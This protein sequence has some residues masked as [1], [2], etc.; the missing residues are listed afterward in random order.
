MRK[1]TLFV[2]LFA[3]VISANMVSVVEAQCGPTPPC[4]PLT[5]LVSYEV[6][7]DKTSYSEM[8]TVTAVVKI[9]NNILYE[10]TAYTLNFYTGMNIVGAW[11][12]TR[13]DDQPCVPTAVD[14]QT[15]TVSV[16]PISTVIGN[17]TI[18]GDMPGTI[19]ISVTGKTPSVKKTTPIVLIRV[20]QERDNCEVVN[21]RRSVSSANISDVDA[22]LSSASAKISD[23]ETEISTAK[24]AG[25][26]ITN[27]Q[28]QLGN[29]QIFYDNA[30]NTY[31]DEGVTSKNKASIMSNCNSA[32]QSGSDIIAGLQSCYS[33][34]GFWGFITGTVVP[35]VLIVVVIL[36]LL[37]FLKRGRW[38]RL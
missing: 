33:S 28:T 14:A 22:C 8:E 18:Y 12:C 19:T 30:N 34:Q 37:M 9:S 1:T 23:A 27:A 11:S 16:A 38:D 20:R 29:A 13:D 2:V 5:T 10:K 4:C 35:V 21:L 15:S 36:F 32:Y 26:D 6:S 25:C 3:L 17:T 7:P 24:K 31:Q